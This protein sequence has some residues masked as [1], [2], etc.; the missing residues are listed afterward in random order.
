MT[1]EQLDR[2]EEKVFRSGFDECWYWTAVTNPDGYGQLR[3]GRKMVLAH[4]LSYEHFV[5]PIPKG[6]Q[7]DHLCRVRGCVNPRHLEP[8][9]QRENI[10]RGVGIAALNAKKTHCK[11]GHE[12]TPENTRPQAH[13]SKDGTKRGR[14]CLA[15]HRLSSKALRDKK[16]VQNV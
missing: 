14:S 8:V 2:F 3:I 9:T 4:H 16:K 12:F 13:I 7:L 10:L 11:N 5:G 15:C 6:L 1:T